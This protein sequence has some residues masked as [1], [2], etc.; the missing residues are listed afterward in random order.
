MTDF[1]R[2]DFL[3]GAAAVPFAGPL[4]GGTPAAKKL[5]PAR[6]WRWLSHLD[7]WDPK[8]DA[9]RIQI[10]EIF[11]DGEART[12]TQLIR[13]VYSDSAPA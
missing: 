11:P 5:Y 9:P 6:H 7:T 12:S 10:S 4:F 2:R 1:A 8:P 3:R 13:S